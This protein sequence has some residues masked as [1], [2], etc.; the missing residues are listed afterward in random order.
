MDRRRNPD[1]PILSELIAVLR[2]HP[3]GLRRWSVMRALRAHRARLSQDIPQKFEE[4]VE[5]TFR[6]FCADV[7]EANSRVCAAESAPFYRPQGTAGEVWALFPDRVA[8]LLNEEDSTA[9]HGD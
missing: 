9:P 1:E 8:A 3:A 2:P 6:R 4:Q 5:R 7:S